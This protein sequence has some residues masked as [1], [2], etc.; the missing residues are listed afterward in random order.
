MQVGSAAQFLAEK[1]QLDV[2]LRHLFY[3]A[4]FRLSPSALTSLSTILRYGFPNL[5]MVLCA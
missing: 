5:A 2:R 3:L 1:Q 4:L